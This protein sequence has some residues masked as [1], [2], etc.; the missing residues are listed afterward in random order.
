M[1]EGLIMFVMFIS[2]FFW[3]CWYMCAKELSFYRNFVVGKDLAR[4]FSEYKFY[5][6]H[7]KFLHSYGSKD[8]CK[9]VLK[10]K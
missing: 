7:G 9:G 8:L 2:L 1:I 6:K 10:Q 4:E 3:F 5:V